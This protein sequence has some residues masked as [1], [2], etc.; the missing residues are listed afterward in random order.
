MERNK[1]IVLILCALLLIGAAGLIFYAYAPP[2][3]VDEPL[4]EIIYPDY[5]LSELFNRSDLIVSGVVI[6]VTEP[7]KMTPDTESAYI[8]E[9][10]METGVSYYYVTLVVKDYFKGRKTSDFVTVKIVSNQT[11][12]TEYNWGDAVF[13]Y[14]AENENSSEESDSDSSS[15]S[16]SVSSSDSSSVSS[17][18]SYLIV[19]PRGE[20]RFVEDIDYYD[21]IALYSNG[22]N[23]TVTYS[24]LSKKRGWIIYQFQGP[25][26]NRLDP[27]KYGLNPLSKRVAGFY[28]DHE[29]VTF[30][31]EYP[32]TKPE[33]TVISNSGA[34]SDSASLSVYIPGANEVTYD[35][36]VYSDLVFYGTV[37][38]E[39]DNFSVYPWNEYVS[40]AG[41]EVI[42]R[43]DDLVKG[44]ASGNVSVMV[45]SGH[46]DGSKLEINRDR[47][48]PV[49]WDLEEGE[50][51]LIYLK[52]SD[53]YT[54]YLEPM[55]HGIFPI[56]T[57]DIEKTG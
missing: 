46:F 53:T 9:E 43:I 49:S 31:F 11:N 56:I 19:T 20:N 28:S 51:Y 55:G 22:L 32:V 7:V 29:N 39:A 36:L 38:K 8:Y 40:I 48:E 42:F 57:D 23:E 27:T 10:L 18:D 4:P 15:D 12:E 50:Q 25:L 30:M 26:Y 37:V 34:I 52:E 24:E 14:L 5:N 3:P 17:S 13:F 2:A 35:L 1:L 47:T 33:E 16:S 6:N 41:S 54:G 21:G 45:Y 44:N